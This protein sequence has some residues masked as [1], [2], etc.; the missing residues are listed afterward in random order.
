MASFQQRS[1][2]WILSSVILLPVLLPAANTS[3]QVQM[4]TFARDAAAKFDAQQ[5]PVPSEGLEV[6]LPGEP[7]RPLLANG[8][9]QI[10]MHFPDLGKIGIF[11]IPAAKFDG[12]IDCLDLNPQ[13]AAG[14]QVLVIYLPSSRL[15]E[16]Y[17]LNTLQS[18]LTVKSPLRG[19]VRFIAMGMK[20]A[21]R[22]FVLSD[23]KDKND[24]EYY[25]PCFLDVPTFAITSFDPYTEQNNNRFLSF[26]F[27]KS[28]P[29]MEGTSDEYGQSFIVRR[30]LVSPPGLAFYAIRG[31]GDLDLTYD[32]IFPSALQ[33]SQNGRF[34]ITKDSILAPRSSED[35][36]KKINPGASFTILAPVAGYGAI[37]EHTDPPSATTDAF[38][39]FHLRGL[40]GLDVIADIP[41][42]DEI[43]PQL[44][45]HHS[46]MRAPIAPRA[47]NPRPAFGGRPGAPPARPMPQPAQRIINEMP[48]TNASFMLSSAYCDR[49][50]YL[51]TAEPKI[52][53][54]NLGL[55]ERDQGTDVAHP[56]A[57]FERKLNLA[58]GTSV[59]VQS[60]PAGLKFD[61][62]SGRLMWDVPKDVKT[63]Q[64]VQVIMLIKTRD[65]KQDYR[66]EK[67]SVP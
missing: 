21:K 35:L 45:V 49:V 24:S 8:G 39:G 19:Q 63:G 59:T 14:G 29:E 65:G 38:H 34:I 43:G 12:F 5:V 53:L 27:I 17:D 16:V 7:N 40:P 41:V 25:A 37:V 55:K 28:A 56:G 51:T 22:I 6:P 15:F 3:E 58:V 26:T 33:F 9:C 32:H 44:I 2:L 61:E 4:D 1:L 11:N 31:A 67:I 52:F 30:P 20:N 18:R 48:G 36:Y 23:D 64:S 47:A 50:A 46:S 60:G 42:G 62:A 54:F 10:V 13:F 57:H 66:I